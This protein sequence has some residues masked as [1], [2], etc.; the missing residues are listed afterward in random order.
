L[1]A[2]IDI[3]CSFQSHSKHFFNFSCEIIALNHGS[4]EI[5]DG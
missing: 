1:R 4:E 2:K 5:I 3:L